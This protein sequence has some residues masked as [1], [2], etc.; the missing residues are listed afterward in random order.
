VS[1][2]SGLVIV[3]AAV[4]TLFVGVFPSWLLDAADLVTAVYSG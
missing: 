2:A 4:F 3:A 1:F